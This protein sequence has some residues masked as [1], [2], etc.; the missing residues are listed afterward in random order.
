MPI[1]GSIKRRDLLRHLRTL[2]FAGPFS[3]G[4]H[5]FM[6]KGTLRI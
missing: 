4:K 1:V 2:G 3:G 6:I 5:Q